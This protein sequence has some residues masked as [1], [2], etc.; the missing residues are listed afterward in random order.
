MR[1]FLGTV[2]FIMDGSGLKET[3]SEICAKY[4][5]AKALSGQ[6]YSRATTGHFLVKLVLSE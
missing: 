5:A 2:G 1:S 6:T 3:F 4:L